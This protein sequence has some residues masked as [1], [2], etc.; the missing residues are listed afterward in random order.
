MSFGA[1][2]KVAGTTFYVSQMDGIVGLGYGTISVNGLPTFIDNSDLKEKSFSFYLKNNP[3]DS[4]MMIPG[5]EF[6]GYAKFSEHDVVEKSYWN[7]DLKNLSGPNGT[8]DTAGMKAAIDSGTSLIVGPASVV[9]SWIQGITVNKDCSGVEALPDLTMRFD[10]TVF[11]LGQQDYVL[12]IGEAEKEQCVLGIQAAQ[13]PD[14]FPYVIVGDVFFRKY[15]P[16][17]D[18]DNN[19]VTFFVELAD[20]IEILQ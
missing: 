17:F 7:L 15:S 12:R 5:F 3:A 11:T 4:Y 1:I 19:K 18:A 20:D 8:T 10:D 14:D 9:D 13:L 2:K 16:F 6:N